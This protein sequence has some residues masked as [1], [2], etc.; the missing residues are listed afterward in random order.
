[1]DVRADIVQVAWFHKPPL[2]EGKL[3]ANKQ[4]VRDSQY[5]GHHRN[6]LIW[7]TRKFHWNDTIWAAVKGHIAKNTLTL[8]WR[9]W[10]RPMKRKLTE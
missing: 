1:M 9:T 5:F 4:N 8:K 2:W 7:P 3:M 6:I 10:R